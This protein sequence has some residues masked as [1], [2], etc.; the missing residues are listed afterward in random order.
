MRS[1][2]IGVVWAVLMVVFAVI[3]AA[4][5]V[6]I[7]DDQHQT[8]S[9]LAQSEHDVATLSSQVESLGATP[10][11]STPP[12]AAGEKGDR[13]ERGVQGPAGPAPSED[14]VRAAVSGYMTAN[15]P[16]AGRPPNAAEIGA[17]VA[18]YCAQG[19]GC[20][21]PAGSD[22]APGSDGQSIIGPR[23]EQGP[24]PSD[25]QVGGAVA[26]YCDARNGCVG[27]PGPAGQ[28]VVGPQGPAGQSVDSFVFAVGPVT[29]L[30]TDPDRNGAFTCA[31]D[32]PPP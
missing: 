32:L 20:R 30:C 16:A 17:A 28:T 2:L 9:A 7:R 10:A 29:Y 14:Q 13:G 21:G 12:P 5:I 6:D 18:A 22:G 11:V 4:I 24:G 25:E 26:A 19:A 15:P 3:V 1:R 31:S 27:P 23:G 8:D